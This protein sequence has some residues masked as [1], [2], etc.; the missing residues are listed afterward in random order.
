MTEAVRLSKRAG[1]QLRTAVGVAWTQAGAPEEGGEGA[2]SGH[3]SEQDQ[4]RHVHG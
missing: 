2:G 4:R 3:I 1:L